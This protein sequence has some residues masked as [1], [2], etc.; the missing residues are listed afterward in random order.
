[1]I[2]ALVC[3][4]RRINPLVGIAAF[5]RAFLLT[6]AVFM[7]AAA[8]R[9]PQPSGELVLDASNPVIMVQIADISVRLRVDLDQ[10]NSVELNPAV[11]ARLPVAWEDGMEMDVGRVRL[12]GKT[13]HAMLR[14]G[15]REFPIQVSQH[16]RDCCQGSDGAI[17]PNLLPFATVRWRRPDA[18]PP[19]GS[20]SY[21]IADNAMTGLSAEA[22]TSKLRLRF[23]LTQQHTVGT[24]AA[25]AI[26]S[27]NRGGHWNGDAGRV[28][29][30]FGISRPAREIAFDTPVRLA[31]FRFDSLLVRTSDFAGG[32]Q[33]PTDPVDPR[34]VVITR[35][36]QRQQAWPAIT[37]GLEHLSRCAELTYTA[38]P[39]TLTLRCAFDPS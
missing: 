28:T 35:H 29:L 15:S 20:R 8:A 23:A 26:L 16:G 22:E 27:R 24:A 37:L 39:R 38:L 4:A 7:L 3:P 25:G 14:V 36:L 32:E 9:P 30:A 19:T 5:K 11:A 13:A 17:G 12:P 10:Q 33:L 31:G 6:P 21:P 34:D 1:M 18:L 2:A